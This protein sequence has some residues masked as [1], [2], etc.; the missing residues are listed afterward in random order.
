M[1]SHSYALEYD[2][3]V[4]RIRSLEG[5]E[6]FMRPKP[7]SQLV[8]ACAAGPVVIIHMHM[9]ESKS[10]ALVLYQAEDVVH[11]PLPDFS[12]ARAKVMQKLMW[13]YLRS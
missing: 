9:L 2:K 10:D 8:G 4:S 1:S 5:F 3:L 12:Y 6:N 7:L 11:I 13:T